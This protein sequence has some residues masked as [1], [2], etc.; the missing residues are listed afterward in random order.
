M[1]ALLGFSTAA[2]A[3]PIEFSQ[4]FSF[5]L[6]PGNTTVDLPQFDDQGGTRTLV[7]V[8]LELSAMIGSNITAENDSVLDAPSFPVGLTGLVNAS[9]TGLSTTVSLIENW[10]FGLSPTDGVAGSGPDYH[11]FGYLSDND[12]DSDSMTDPPDDLSAFVGP[13]TITVNIDGSAGWSF[14]GTTDATLVIDNLG[15]S[16]TAKIIYTYVPEPASMMMLGLGLV[17]VIRR[18]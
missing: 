6:S 13:G 9:T 2:I 15:A 7:S 17:G 18:R 10:P 11:D 12:V 16:G 14:Q 5:P 3:N 8:E 1:A 4:P